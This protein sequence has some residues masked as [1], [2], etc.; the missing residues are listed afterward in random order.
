MK[1]KT[2]LRRPSRWS[3]VEC[4]ISTSYSSPI[5]EVLSRRYIGASPTP[6]MCGRDPG[7]SKR[8][9]FCDVHCI[10]IR[11]DI[12]VLPMKHLILMFWSRTVPERIK[13]AYLSC[14]VW[15]FV[16]SLSTALNVSALGIQMSYIRVLKFV[17]GVPMWIFLVTIAKK[18]KS[19][20]IAEQPLHLT[21]AWRLPQPVFYTSGRSRPQLLCP[22]WEIQKEILPVKKSF[23]L[24]THAISLH[25]EI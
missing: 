10:T 5:T 18:L 22:M 6:C 12:R 15:P 4:T 23:P 21:P 2:A 24:K 19:V 8:T 11:R 9:L 16:P 20:P 7:A 1:G 13:S 17:L 3:L 14:R 25:L